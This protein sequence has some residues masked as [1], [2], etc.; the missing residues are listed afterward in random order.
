MMRSVA[1]VLCCGLSLAACTQDGPTGRP[2]SFEFLTTGTE[3]AKPVH[4][5]E[6][7]PGPA[8][9]PPSNTF[10]GR[11]RVANGSKVDH[12]LLLFDELGL[13]TPDSPGFDSLPE[14]AFEFVQ[15]G[16]LLIPMVTGPVINTHP[17]WEFAFGTGRTWDEPDDKGWTRA[18]VPFALKERRE[19]CTHNGLLTFLFRD[20]GDVS[21]VAFQLT[22]QTC[23]YLQFDMSGLLA[24]EYRPG[25]V[26]GA[27]ETIAAVRT[28]RDTRIPTRPISE[29]S[30]TYAAANAEAF[31]SVAEIAPED[32]TAY[33]FVIDG[34]HYVGEC[35]T[36][37]GPYPYCDEMALPSYSTAKSVVAG[38]GL[39]LLEA[40]YPGAAQTVIADL[41]Q[42]CSDGWH[43][44][45]I[46]HALDMTTGHFELPDM[47][48]D[49]DAAIASD[50]FLGDHRDKIDTA[51]KRF[52][53]KA[54][55]GTH[56]SY[57]TWDTYLAGV[58]M[59][60]FLR[61][62]HGPQA[63]FFNDL[64]VNSIWE[65]LGLSRIAAATR[66]TYD[67]FRHPHAGFGLTLLRDDMVRLAQFIGPLDGRLEGQDILDRRLFDAIKQRVPGDPGMEAELPTIRYNNGFR[68]FDV[69]SYLGCSEPA[70]VV[71]LSGF[72][73]IIVAIMPNDTTYYY[74]SDGNDV[75]YLNAVRE[76]HK[77]RPMCAN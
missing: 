18:G 11:L 15:D 27:E 77:I 68:T 28:N 76:S 26:A 29:I 30:K 42:E 9:L 5:S 36:P 57:H 37:Y 51:C 4:T 59:T 32:M 73:G 24:A 16:D 21:N 34:I 61:E 75:R 54:D 6:Y 74:F 72:G 65:P 60:N 64:L 7:A 43:D 71:V 47:H 44:V 19:D 10:H 17:W 58:A 3:L 35:R 52:P 41:V 13:I 23:R 39:M 66:R 67:E 12:F 31:G 22:S 70:W 62:R 56:L 25:D 33:G 53:R 2:L 40:Q 8:S 14:F 48:G 20:S 1:L 63:D 46:E 49:E 55:P 38:F 50:F 45:T 69:S